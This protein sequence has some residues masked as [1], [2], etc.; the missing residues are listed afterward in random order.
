MAKQTITDETKSQ[1]KPKVKRRF[2]VEVQGIAPVVLQLETWAYDEEEALKQLDNP[3]LMSLRDRPDID[4]SRLRRHKVTIKDALSS[5][6]KIVK[7]F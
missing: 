4:L 3:R 2:V 5:L 7:S 6:I 1:E